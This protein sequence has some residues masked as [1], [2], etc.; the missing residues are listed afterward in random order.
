VDQIISESELYKWLD[1]LWKNIDQQYIHF[2]E[3][4][5]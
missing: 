5:N 3:F 4:R 1:Y 2:I